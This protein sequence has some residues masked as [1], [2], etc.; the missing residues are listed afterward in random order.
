MAVPEDGEGPG[1]QTD[2]QTDNGGTDAVLL[3]SCPVPRS[4]CLPSQARHK[5][6][7]WLKRSGVL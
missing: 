3:L 6:T 2:R 5:R 1:G 7:V 4:L